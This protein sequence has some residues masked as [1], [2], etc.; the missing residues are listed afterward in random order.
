MEILIYALIEL[1]VPLTILALVLLCDVICFIGNLIIFVVE[2]ICFIKGKPSP[3]ETAPKQQ[4]PPLHGEP[5]STAITK[6]AGKKWSRRLLWA[7]GIVLV[8]LVLMVT[9]ANLF[10]FDSTVR[11]MARYATKGTGIYISFDDVS[12]S[13][14]TGK[15]DFTGLNVTRSSQSANKFAI[16]VDSAKV[17][18]SMAALPWQRIVV[19]SLAVKGCGEAGKR[20][21]G[22]AGTRLAAPS[23]SRTFIFPTCRCSMPTASPAPRRLRSR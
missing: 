16:S 14:W 9:V 18:I 11:T 22:P 6:S 19:E 17:D 10:F 2:I 15:F 23:G 3:F 13:L 7:C 5:A 21:D 8:V 1:F 20:E 12:G 4:P